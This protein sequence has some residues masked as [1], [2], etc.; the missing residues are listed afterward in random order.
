MWLLSSNQSN[1]SSIWTFQVNGHGGVNWS[2]C[3]V[4]KKEKKMGE[5]VVRLCTEREPS[6]IHWRYVSFYLP[7]FSR[8][9]ESKFS[10]PIQTFTWCLNNGIES[11]HSFVAS[12]VI[13]TN[14]CR[15]ILLHVLRSKVNILHLKANEMMK[16]AKPT[17][18]NAISCA[19]KNTEW[20]AEVRNLLGFC[21]KASHYYRLVQPFRWECPSSHQPTHPWKKWRV[22]ILKI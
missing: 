15:A 20:P 12:R 9:Y 1:W 16:E 21:Y 11:L 6:Q 17:M 22:S 2:R 14:S 7:A 19:A 5:K 10:V 3:S 18:A 13:Y 8:K 4:E